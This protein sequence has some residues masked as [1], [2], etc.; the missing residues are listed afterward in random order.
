MK[1]IITLLLLNYIGCSIPTSKRNKFQND[2]IGEWYYA[3]EE[4]IVSDTTKKPSPPSPLVTRNGYKFSEGGM[5]ELKQG[6]HKTLKIEDYHVS[7]FMGYTTTYKIE[8]DS[9]KIFSLSLNRWYCQKIL[10]LTK[11][12][13]WLLR[14]DSINN[15][16]DYIEKYAHFQE[17]NNEN[18]IFDK[19]ILSSSGCFGSCP[20]LKI[21]IEANGKAAFLGENY[22]TRNG[23]FRATISKEKFEDIAHHFKKVDLRTFPNDFDSYDS[24]GNTILIQFWRRNKCV[25][26]VRDYGRISPSPFVCA[27]TRLINLYQEL[28]WTK[29]DKKQFDGDKMPPQ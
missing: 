4:F 17:L 12:S 2:I 10:K 11:D 3:S 20:V 6:F 21:V 14:I 7:Q 29:I 27:Y 24:D 16:L 1:Y 28:E 8:D 23:Y 19:V 15:R 18:L 25:K 13:L 5:F 22:T 26:T 9:L